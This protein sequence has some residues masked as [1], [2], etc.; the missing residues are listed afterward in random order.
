MFHKKEA[1]IAE[2]HDELQKLLDGR[3]DI[4]EVI[5]MN[6]VYE[7][8]DGLLKDSVKALKC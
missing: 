8:V 5:G 3:A 6:P 2:V 7:S 1:A 4:H